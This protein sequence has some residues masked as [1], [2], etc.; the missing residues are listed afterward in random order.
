MIP[1]RRVASSESYFRSRFFA[2][3]KTFAGFVEVPHKVRSPAE[4]D[5][6][7]FAF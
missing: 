6:E 4:I 2:M 7:R 5:W 1:R 3:K